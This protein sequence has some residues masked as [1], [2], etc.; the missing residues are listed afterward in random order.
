MVDSHRLVAM[1]SCAKT[2]VV[3]TFD[4]SCRTV[5]AVDMVVDNL[6]DNFPPGLIV[7]CTNGLVLRPGG[8]THPGRLAAWSSV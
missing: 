3:L 2:S 1:L 4:K 7:P 6:V 5:A 8:P